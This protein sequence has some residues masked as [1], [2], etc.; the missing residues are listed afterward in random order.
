MLEQPWNLSGCRN[1]PHVAA[2]EPQVA[3]A[4]PLLVRPSSLLDVEVKPAGAS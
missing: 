4:V 3:Q 2:E 1:E